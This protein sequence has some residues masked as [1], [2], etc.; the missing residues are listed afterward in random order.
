MASKIVESARYP[1]DLQL[2]A[3]L[4]KSTPTATPTESAVNSDKNDDVIIVHEHK[5][6]D[7]QNGRHYEK[8]N[9]ENPIPS[10][11]TDRDNPQRSTLSITGDGTVCALL[12][13]MS[14]SKRKQR[15]R[16]DS[17]S[18]ANWC[19]E[20]TKRQNTHIT[21]MLMRTQMVS[22][23]MLKKNQMLLYQWVRGD[24]NRCG[25]REVYLRSRTHG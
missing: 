8:T 9:Y 3:P 21:S 10:R 11:V 24:Y 14:I 15:F 20:T 22:S 2:H 25:L 16:L 7:P 12:A 4:P 13:R 19:R 6:P 17:K 18:S 5:K 1:A 23:D